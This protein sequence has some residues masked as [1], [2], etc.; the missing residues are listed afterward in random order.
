MMGPYVH[1][2]RLG[3]EIR[4]LRAGTGLTAAQLARKIG[5]SRAGIS[6]LENGH[7]VDQADVLKIL[8]AAG[9]NE[10]RPGG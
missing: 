2:L 8:D 9:V 3:A 10:D 4:S 1:R 6:R 7:A 5:R